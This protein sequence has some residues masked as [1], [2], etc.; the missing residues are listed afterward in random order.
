MIP[1]ILYYITDLNFMLPGKGIYSIRDGSR[2]GLSF[3]FC[4]DGRWV[5]AGIFVPSAHLC[6]SF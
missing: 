1:P 3:P 6:L 5:V 2:D 4:S